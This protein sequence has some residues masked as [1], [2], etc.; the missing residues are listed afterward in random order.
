MIESDHKIE[1]LSRSP[2]QNDTEIFL[3]GRKLENHFEKLRIFAKCFERFLN[4]CKNAKRPIFQANLPP[5]SF[6]YGKKVIFHN[7]RRGKTKKNVHLRFLNFE[8]SSHTFFNDRKSIFQKFK[9]CEIMKKMEI[10][11]TVLQKCITFKND[12]QILGLV[13]SFFGSSPSFFTP[14]FLLGAQEAFDPNQIFSDHE[15]N[16]KIDL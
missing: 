10:S 15:I 3:R 7:D 1:S 4:F 9:I 2:Q 13:K 5:D 6:E 8:N 16:L 11:Q 12:F 14:N